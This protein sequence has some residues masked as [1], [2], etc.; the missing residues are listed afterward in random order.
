MVFR[1]GLG[2][3][4]VSA[5]FSQETLP[6]RIQTEAVRRV[7]VPSEAGSSQD[8]ASGFV[9]PEPPGWLRRPGGGMRLASYQVPGLTQEAT[10]L[11]LPGEGGGLEANARRFL[12]QM[13]VTPRRSEVA[14]LLA[15]LRTGSSVGGQ[16]FTVLD[17][18]GFATSATSPCVLAIH[19]DTPQ[20]A[21]WLRLIGETKNVLAQKSAA[22]AWAA[23]FR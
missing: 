6:Q 8:R 22:E 2:A 10:V 1:L 7:P 5:L 9:L 13:F 3:L 16:R 18:S 17:L 21:V 11:L 20:G 14:R 19:L 23:A 12:A 4:L 15:E